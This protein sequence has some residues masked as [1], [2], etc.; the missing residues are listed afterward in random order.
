MT[1]TLEQTDLSPVITLERLRDKWKTVPAAGPGRIG[2]DE[3][4]TWSDEA[5][6]AF[7][8]EQRRRDTTCEGFSIRGWY[9]ALYKDVLKG[10]RVL[11]VGA[12]LGMDAFTFAQAGARMTLL[13]IAESNVELQRRLGKLLK[14][15]T[16]HH[17]MDYVESLDKLQGPFDLIFAQGS[18]I[19][20]PLPQMQAQCAK[21]LRHL[22]V[23]GR[24]VEL[25]YPKERWVREGKLSQDKWGPKTDGPGTPWIE[26]YDLPKLLQRLSPAKFDVVLAFNFHNDDFNWFDLIRTA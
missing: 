16:Q 25:C 4:L 3:L 19:N 10:K 8:Q 18:L 26:W 24:W 2:T 7:W 15:D 20:A 22:P 9:H 13:D 1:T 6:L 23:G 5:L 21:L 11:D 14:L 17:W 12:G